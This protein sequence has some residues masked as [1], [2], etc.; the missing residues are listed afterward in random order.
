MSKKPYDEK[1]HAARLEGAASSAA[2]VIPLLLDLFPW[3]TSV[4]DAGCS[5]GAWLHEFQLH[6]ISRLLG[7]D[8]ANIPP[9]LLQIDVSQFRQIDLCRPLPPLGRFDLA[10]S[11]EVGD[12]L[13][14]DVAQQFVAGLTGLSDVVVFSAAAPGQSKQQTLHER[15]P[16]YWRGLFADCR[17]TCFDI[18][19]ERLWYDQRV[20][21]WYSQ[22]MLV[23]VSEFRKDLL[24]GLPATRRAAMLDI[25]HPRA[26]ECFRTEAS[27]GGD[28]RLLLYPFR[29]IEAGYEG[30]DIVQIDTDTF[31]A[32]AKTEGPY[33]PEKLVA[34]GY[35]R[36]YVGA[37]V[38][39]V[40]TRIPHEMFRVTLVEEG[41]DG[42]DILQIGVNKFI[43]LLQSDG[44]Y[45]PEKFA[46]GGY[47]RAHTAASINKVKR[48]I[49]LARG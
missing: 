38:D 19:R 13:P 1:Y 46:A 24:N 15:W 49:E 3:V 21:W 40:K 5:A 27:V 22:N 11:L 48:A 26:F 33:S 4:V 14:G 37:S 16:S 2:V 31:L 45:S 10:L 35:S 34:G 8:R 44:P 23:F 32:L 12:C 20:D 28:V 42:Y 18:L 17:F 6:G 41:Y 29:M 43:A 7:I 25:V 9:R 36:A 47:E 30:H 39:E